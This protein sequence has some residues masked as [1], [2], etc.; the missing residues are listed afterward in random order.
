MSRR[1]LLLVTLAVGLVM[2]A[3]AVA[4]PGVGHRVERLDVP[5]AAPGE[6]RKLDVHVWYPAD[7]TTQPKTVYT[8]ALHGKPLP[9]GW[10]P[11]SW[12]V[13]AELAR[14]G[15]DFDPSKGSPSGS[16]L[17]IRYCEPTPVSRMH[18]AGVMQVAV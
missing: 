6:L 11:L 16:T 13:E 9:N 1:R 7:V 18:M 15:A 3:S 8:S 5:G 4:A 17:A 12:S 14:E 2:P 10:A